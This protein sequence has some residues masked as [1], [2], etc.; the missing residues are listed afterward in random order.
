VFSYK[1]RQN[2][3][4]LCELLM[5]SSVM[6]HESLAVYSASLLEQIW[7]QIALVSFCM[8]NSYSLLV[9]IVQ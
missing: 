8:F 1:N 6:H 4:A 9:I 3:V 2:D 5:P 7:A